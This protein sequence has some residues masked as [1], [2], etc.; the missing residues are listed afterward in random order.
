[1]N[2][3]SLVPTPDAIPAPAWLF[4]LLG[5]VMFALHILVINTLLG[6]SIIMLVG[7]LVRKK[8][9]TPVVLAQNTAVKTMA[10][11]AFGI[12][13]GVAALLFL[14]VLYGHFMY[15]SSVLMAVYWILVI[16]LLILAY[17]AGYLHIRSTSP[18]ISIVALSVSTAILLYIGFV[19]VNNM[20]LML[21]PEKWT[22]YFANRGGTVLNTSDPIFW[23][24]YVHFLVASV[25]VSGVFLALV[26]AHRAKKGIA[27]T[28]L[29]IVTGLHIYAW[30][31]CL[32]V[33]IGLWFLLSLPKD[34]MMSFMGGNLIHTIIL[35]LGILLALGAI[36]M[37]FKGKLKATLYHLLAIVFLMVIN[38]ANLRSLYL[39]EHFSFQSLELSPQYGVLALFLLILLIGL[40]A[41]YYMIKIVT[42]ANQGRAAS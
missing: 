41:V 27:S 42:K 22:A 14:Q 19:Y 31:T 8:A 5:I 40:G 16:P 35:A 34:I 38:R 18:T 17:Y 23:P 36:F 15:T 39:K 20:T 7:R 9:E 33:L 21:M 11:F 10:L 6:S 1:M 3:T 28:G 37:A 25:A 12:N 26:Q 4:W 2:P 13:L 32:Q 24:R 29:K 30:A